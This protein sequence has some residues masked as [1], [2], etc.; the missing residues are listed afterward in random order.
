MSTAKKIRAAYYV[1]LSG[2][3]IQALEEF[4]RAYTD[5]FDFFL[6]QSSHIPSVQDMLI[7]AVTVLLVLT[8][9]GNLI[10]QMLRFSAQTLMALI[11]TFVRTLFHNKA[12]YEFRN[13]YIRN[14]D[15]LKAE[16]FHPTSDAK[17]EIP[18]LTLDLSHQTETP[19]YTSLSSVR[20]VLNKYKQPQPTLKLIKEAHL[21]YQKSGLLATNTTNTTN[22]TN[23]K[24]PS[25][26]TLDPTSAAEGSSWFPEIPGAKKM[27]SFVEKMMFW[28]DKALNVYT[29]GKDFL[30]SLTSWISNM[31]ETSPQGKVII[32]SV[33]IGLINLM[34]FSMITTLSPALGPTTVKYLIII[35][36]GFTAILCRYLFRDG[37]KYTILEMI[38]NVIRQI[39]LVVMMVTK[40]VSSVTRAERDVAIQGLSTQDLFSNESTKQVQQLKQSSQQL[41]MLL[42]VTTP[43]SPL[44]VEQKQFFVELEIVRR[45][46]RVLKQ[47]RKHHYP[48][49]PIALHPDLLHVAQSI[50]KVYLTKTFLSTRHVV[51]FFRWIYLAFQDEEEPVTVAPKTVTPQKESATEA[52]QKVLQL[53]LKMSEIDPPGYTISHLKSIMK[54]TQAITDFLSNTK[55]LLVQLETHF[56]H[57]Q[58]WQKLRQTSLELST[59]FLKE[60]WDNIFTCVNELKTAATGFLN[61]GHWNFMFQTALLVPWGPWK[62]SM[63][64]RFCEENH[65]PTWHQLQELNPW[66]IR[67]ER[68][69][70]SDE[71]K[72]DQWYMEYKEIYLKSILWSRV[73]IL[74]YCVC[75]AAFFMGMKFIMNETHL[76]QCFVWA[77]EKFID[78]A[79][80][81]QLT[82]KLT[83][84]LST[85]PITELNH[86]P[87]NDTNYLLQYHNT[88]WIS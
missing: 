11:K 29:G 69:S 87:W 26:T 34:F 53:Q 41:Q 25:T 28:H 76:D 66:L 24:N 75:A 55:Q 10:P 3:P 14:L 13:G 37:I 7:V 57:L 64:A 22:I 8:I 49:Q 74:G 32:Y 50:S 18:T 51:N 23:T 39:S 80:L 35:M 36:L 81:I 78:T 40:H 48:D 67:P 65:I 54:L 52:L 15:R 31:Y 59:T 62:Y 70:V 85:H 61:D 46:V 58:T 73:G 33:V 88:L 12:K 16:L 60:T 79:S 6:Q 77:Q 9:S 4:V 56:T 5:V 86:I 20:N 17:I 71:S 47:M 44:T 83:T 84:I 30:Y 72:V 45:V 42:E 68:T 2:D 63:I 82:E 27:F 43:G 21:K 19:V 38:E 1:F